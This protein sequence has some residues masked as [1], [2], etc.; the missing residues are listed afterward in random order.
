MEY[1]TEQE[2][3][4]PVMEKVDVVVVGGGPSGLMA[5]IASARNGADTVIIEKHGSET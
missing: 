4:T 2:R 1:V 3:K 5:A